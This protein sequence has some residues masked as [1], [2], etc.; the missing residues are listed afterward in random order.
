[1]AFH[2]DVKALL[3][4]VFGTCVD[5]RSTVTKALVQTSK[6][7]ITSPPSNA[8]TA[9]I[10]KASELSV[11]DWGKFAQE[12]RDTYYVYVKS[13]A[14]GESEWKTI[15]QHHHDS[16]LELLESWSLQGL[17]S[18][19]EI[20]KLSLVWHYLDPWPE[21]VEGMNYLNT[22]YQTGTLSNGNMD[23]LKDLKVYSGLEFKHLFSSEL[24]GSYK[25][26]PNVYLGAVQKLGLEPSQVLMVAAHTHDLKAAKSCGLLTAFVDRPGELNSPELD[27]EEAKS[28]GYVDVWVSVQELGFVALAKKL[29][30]TINE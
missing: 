24:F 3:F 13:V 25:P 22:K 21:A 7:T 29:G 28:G 18:P 8:S 15:D 14:Q 1:M 27:R 23:L 2:S 20:K 17:W 19:D 4:D 12:W 6:A 9:A 26:S 5:W 30:I 10:K 16:L 11:E